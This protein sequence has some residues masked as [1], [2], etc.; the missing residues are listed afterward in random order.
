MKKWTI[1]FVLLISY[2]LSLKA[3]YPDLIITNG[4]KVYNCRITKMDEVNIYFKLKIKGVDRETN[5]KISD[6][7]SYEWKSKNT[8]SKTAQPCS[9]MY[10]LSAGDHL[11]KAKENLIG[12][13]VIS[14]VGGTL[15]VALITKDPANGIIF[16]G[17]SVL[18]GSILQIIGIN[19]I[20][21]SGLK[22]N[23]Q[24]ST[25]LYLQ[26]ANNGIGLTYHF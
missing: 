2:T 5:I 23:E 11:I 7:M 17:C 9:T 16:A 1:L 10:G 24:N 13:F 14:L 26:P 19:H 25:S 21:K 8:I 20:G 22:L 18:V 3:Q 4:N 6:V 15:G 12:G